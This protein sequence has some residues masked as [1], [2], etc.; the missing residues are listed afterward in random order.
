[1]CRQGASVIQKQVLDTVKDPSIRVY[2]AW[3][4]ILPSDG[5]APDKDTLALVPDKRASHFWDAKGTLPVLFQKPLG[6]PKECVA[7]DVYLIYPPG[8]RWESE[9]PKPVYWQHQLGGVTTAPR[10]EGKTFAS[11]L[12]KVLKTT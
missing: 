6:L 12:R 5:S 2:V 3:V 7:W 1:M 8:V 10:L 4:P 11:R 9:P